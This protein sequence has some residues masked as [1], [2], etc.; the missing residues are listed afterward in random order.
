MNKETTLEN[1]KFPIGK[2]Q[3]P[4]VI[5]EAHLKTWIEAIESLSSK[6]NQH[7]FLNFYF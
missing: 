4:E 5:S 7:D 1:L 6:I 3:K 2:F